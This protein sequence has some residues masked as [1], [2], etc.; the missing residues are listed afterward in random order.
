MNSYSD[1]ALMTKVRA[2]YGKGLHAEDYR[3]LLQ[4][5]TVG[6][7]ASYLKEETSYKES[8]AEVQEEL[9]HR[10]Q[11]E[12]LLRKRVLNVSLSLLK[13]SYD[14]KL[15]L[16]VYTMQNEVTELLEAIRLLN[17]GESGRYIVAL[18][19]YLA[20]Y[21]SFDLYGLA[22]I[23]SFDGLLEVLAHSPYYEVLASF[24]PA[25]G[26]QSI[27]IAACER[28][29]LTH[30]F[31]TLQTYV[32]EHYRGSTRD[33]LEDLFHFQ[34]D[35][36]NLTTLFRLKRFYRYTP[37]QLREVVLPLE[38]ALSSRFYQRLLETRDDR[39]FLEVLSGHSRAVRRYDLGRQADGTDIVGQLGRIQQ[40]SALKAFRFSSRPIVVVINYLTLLEIEVSN[41]IHIIE[42]IRYE[43]PAE[44]ISA[45]LTIEEKR[46]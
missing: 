42:G 25:R 12:N 5:K 44:E 7:I 9:I 39:E 31:S 23:K 36:H 21:L 8:L 2:L 17:A 26:N 15:F 16:M 41:I 28:A 29:L 10:G 38:G 27:N 30:Y 32:K 6:A 43:M 14:D 40:R 18:P 33:S 11:L 13:Y 20:R 34:I 24:R 35:E 1:N 45:L 22:A 3:K 19:A 4:A 37:D 46:A